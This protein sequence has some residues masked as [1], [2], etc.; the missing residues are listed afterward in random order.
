MRGSPSPFGKLPDHHILP[1]TQSRLLP[2]SSPSLSVSIQGIGT[3]PRLWRLRFCP[4]SDVSP[5][6]GR[7]WES[8]KSIAVD[9][10][11]GYFERAGCSV[12]LLVR[13]LAIIATR[14]SPSPSVVLTRQDILTER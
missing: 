13:Y 3:D 11:G 10:E 5:P 2:N 4:S 8:W 1:F 6:K 9:A 7:E 14:T 12:E